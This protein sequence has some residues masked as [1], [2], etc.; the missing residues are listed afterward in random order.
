[1]CSA[2]RRRATGDGGSPMT[3][4]SCPA[5]GLAVSFRNDEPLD[6]SEHCP[7]AWRKAVE[8]CRY[9]SDLGG[10][11]PASRRSG[12]S[13]TFCASMPVVP[14][15]LERFDR[16]PATRE[17]NSVIRVAS[18][19]LEST[20]MPCCAVRPAVCRLLRTADTNSA[21]CRAKP[22][23]TAPVPCRVRT[24]CSRRPTCDCSGRSRSRSAS[25]AGG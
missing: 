18:V 9:D 3:K 7:V 15:A 21:R 6:S 4:M 1:M 17:A 14:S 24:N 10:R 22:S 13:S 11:L 20:R 5:C 25:I 19:P 23:R 16:N 12:V 2:A 8:H